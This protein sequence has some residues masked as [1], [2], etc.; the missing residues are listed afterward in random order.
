MAEPNDRKLGNKGA[1]AGASGVVS[2]S[3]SKRI[4][5]ASLGGQE[6]IILKL[7]KKIRFISV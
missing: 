1:N 6:K 5:A 7:K 2:K 3:V 4:R